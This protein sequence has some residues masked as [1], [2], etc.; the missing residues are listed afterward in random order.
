MS[1]RKRTV[2]T[3]Q[4]SELIDQLSGIL[5]NISDSQDGD[6]SSLQGFL[7]KG[8]GSQILQTWALQ[9]QVSLTVIVNMGFADF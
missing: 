2:S 1:K 4:D 6:V 3:D 7:D 8:Y 9:S 5:S